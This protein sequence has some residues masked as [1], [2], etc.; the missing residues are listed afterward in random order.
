MAAVGA[1]HIRRWLLSWDSLGQSLSLGLTYLKG[2]IKVERGRH[3]Y[4]TL[5]SLEDKWD[6]NVVINKAKNKTE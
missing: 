4:S 1:R 5:G 3:V 2:R 6:R